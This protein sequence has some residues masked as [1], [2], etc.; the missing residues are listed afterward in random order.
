MNSLEHIKNIDIY[1]LDQMLKGRIQPSHKILDAG[2]GTGRNIKLLIN[3]GYTVAAIDEKEAVIN[4]LKSSY[5]DIQQ[6]FTNTSIEDFK[7]TEQFDFI[8]CNAVLHFAG[9]H[10]QFDQQFEQLI[11]LLSCQGTLFVRMTTDIGI[12]ELL[13]TNN[14][15]VYNLPD[16]TTRYLITNDKLNQLLAKHELE[17]IE[18]VKTVVVAGKRSMATLVFKRK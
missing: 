17:L 3:E 11:S 15:G 6:N 18:P 12:K 10:E 7:T 4:E 16:H 5:P 14:D 1:L 2:C 9:G 13:S 8:I